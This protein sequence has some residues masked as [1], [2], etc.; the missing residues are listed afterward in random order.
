MMNSRPVLGR[1]VFAS[2]L[3]VTTIAFAQTPAA[4]PSMIYACVKSTG[5]PA[6]GRLL[7][8]VVGN[9]PCGPNEIRLAWNVVGPKGDIGPQGPAG[10][11]GPMGPQGSIGLQGPQGV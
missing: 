4:Q 10:P 11:M 8:V 5:D 6:A 2:A 3:A 7:R 1:V 9:E